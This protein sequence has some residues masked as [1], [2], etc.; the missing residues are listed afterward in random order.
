MTWAGFEHMIHRL[1]EWRVTA[2][3]HRVVLSRSFSLLPTVSPS[4]YIAVCAHL[5]FLSSCLFSKSHGSLGKL[6]RG[7]IAIFFISP[8][9]W[10]SLYESISLSV[11]FSLSRSPRLF[12]SLSSLPLPM[13]WS[14]SS[15]MLEPRIAEQYDRT[16]IN[17]TCIRRHAKSR[18]CCDVSANVKSWWKLCNGNVTT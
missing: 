3:L 2:L 4:R 12:H 17:V 5:T 14:H 11:S 13:D 1:L 8:S 18:V 15:A 16:F 9:F 7:E 10:H 6:Q